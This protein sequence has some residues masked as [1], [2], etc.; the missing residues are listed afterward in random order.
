MKMTLFQICEH[1]LSYL[2]I[3]PSRRLEKSLEVL[4]V[5]L[6]VHRKSRSPRSPGSSPLEVSKSRK[7][8]SM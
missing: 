2:T 1:D 4:E 7:S 6:E 5:L 8:K 3:T